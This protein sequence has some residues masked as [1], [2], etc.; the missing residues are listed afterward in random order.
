ANSHTGQ[1]NY[2]AQTGR[3]DGSIRPKP[4]PIFTLASLG[5]ST[6]GKKSVRFFAEQLHC[7]HPK[8]KDNSS[9]HEVERN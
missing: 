4:D 6:D 5:A 8:R 2:A 1:R 3:T 9:W 7:N